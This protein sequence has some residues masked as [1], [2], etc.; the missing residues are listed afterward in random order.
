M[1]SIVNYDTPAL[2]P[3]RATDNY[4]TIDYG[5]SS[6]IAGEQLVCGYHL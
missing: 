2:V 5:S 1:V 4:V 6:S 3:G